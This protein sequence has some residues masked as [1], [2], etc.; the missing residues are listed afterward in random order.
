[1]T[2]NF[3]FELGVEELPATVCEQAIAQLNDIYSKLFAENN[4]VYADFHIYA[5]PRRLVVHINELSEVQK[6]SEVDLKGPPVNQAY[7][8]DAATPALL[9]FCKSKGIKLEDTY[10]VSYPNGKFVHGKQ[11]TVGQRVDA[12]MPDILIDGIKKL[13]FARMMRLDSDFRFSRPLKWLFCMHGENVV[14]MEFE[15]MKSSDRTYGHRILSPDFIHIRSADTYFEQLEKSFVIV[16]QVKRD[17]MIESAIKELTEKMGT[18]ALSNEGLL[19]EL[20]YITEHPSLVVGSFDKDFLEVPAEVLVTVMQSHQRYLP[21][22]DRSGKLTNEFIIVS[23]GDPAKASIIRQGNERVLRA[24]LSD[25]SFFYSEDCKVKIEDRFDKLNNIVYQEELGSVADK[26][27]RVATLANSIAEVLSLGPDMIDQINSVA[28]LSK[29]DLTT[30][31]V[32]EFTELQGIMGEKYA[33]RDGYEAVVARGIREYYLPK[34]ASDPIPSDVVGQIVALSDKLDTLV[35]CFGVGIIPTGSADQYGLRRAAIG[36]IRIILESKLDLDIGELINFALEN[37]KK[38]RRLKNGIKATREL[39]TDFI[40]QRFR[41]ILLDDNISY[42]V[43]DASLGV[44]NPLENIHKVYATAVTLTEKRKD[45]EFEEFL[46]ALTRCIRL[47]QNIEKFSHVSEKLFDDISEGELY[48][49]F[50][51]VEGKINPNT[52]I[53][54][55]VEEL[56]RLTGHINMF[57]ENVMVM[58][59]DNRVRANR[60]NLLNE[61]TCLSKIIADFSKIIKN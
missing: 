35:G 45:R 9:G 30:Q 27:H 16:S 21:M 56:Y 22:A 32:M 34:G 7:K 8:D 31:V 26:V 12:I 60:L 59:D 14:P 46:Q 28:A 17:K 24:R 38:G 50:K 61:I 40:Y 42:D 4:L 55:A 36:I 5:T 37:Y 41:N 44:S 13:S 39:V 6:D 20:V 33:L 58:V 18:K 53:K 19:T 3:V 54:N 48:K 11:K 15:G 43:A 49:E 2:K 51:L 47:T 29:N 23:N 1:M 10:I 57:F 52:S 25:A